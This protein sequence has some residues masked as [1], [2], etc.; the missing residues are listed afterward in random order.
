MDYLH[1]TAIAL[2]GVRTENVQII[3][4]VKSI[5]DP[6]RGELYKLAIKLSRL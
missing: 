1:G 5:R 2:A 3:V 4:P 6:Y